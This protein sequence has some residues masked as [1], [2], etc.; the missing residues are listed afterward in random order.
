MVIKH[1]LG[2]VILTGQGSEAS[3]GK[4]FTKLIPC[5]ELSRLW[6]SGITGGNRVSLVAVVGSWVAGLAKGGAEM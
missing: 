2:S 4:G 5:K 3:F 1:G 6:D